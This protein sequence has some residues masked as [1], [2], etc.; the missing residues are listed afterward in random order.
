M[1][2]PQTEH[3]AFEEEV[4]YR[5]RSMDKDERMRLA[6]YLKYLE[7]QRRIDENSD[8]IPGDAEEVLL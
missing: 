1:L 5:I 2:P 3:E 7:Y 6:E 4:I 8:T